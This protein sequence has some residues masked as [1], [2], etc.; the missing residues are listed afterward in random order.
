MNWEMLHKYIQGSC[1]EHEL[2][3]LGEWLKED[4]A[5]ED[6]FK[7]F[8]EQW[9]EQEVNDLEVDARTAWQQFKIRNNL[10][11]TFSTHARLRPIDNNDALKRYP[12]SENHSKNTRHRGYHYWLLVAAA[13]VILIAA[14]LVSA[15][16]WMGTVNPSYNAEVASQEITTAK[17]QRTNLRL[18]DGS[19]VTLN[20]ES[21]L[22]I[23]ENYGMPQRTIYLE[24]E[25]FFEVE[26][27]EQHP[28][29]V[30]TPQGF[31]KDLGTQ[32]NVMAYDSSRVEVAVK[33]GLASLGTVKGDTMQKELVELSADKLGILKRVGG[34]TVSDI[35]DM[36][37][38]TGWAEGKL[39]FNETPFQEVVE[40]L[41]RW[42]NIEC[43]IEDAA[44]KDRTL[45][46]TYSDMP[47]DEVLKV[48]AISLRVSHEREERT[49]T[50]RAK[51]NNNN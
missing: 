45:T 2:R 48:V 34:L 17:G 5:N 25:A 27:D 31:V 43:I 36:Q 29:V 20:A 47:L 24:G 33:E 15:Q 51:T 39:V 16:H 1:S 13:A 40:R 37:L 46:A 42:F 30:I 6:F 12:V 41:E 8:I 19:R 11:S 22:K 50:F 4:P 44:L 21:R 28:F 32:F 26:H 9:D 3:Q 35:A 7:T 10:Q 23:P 14:L 38:F 18:S 49:V